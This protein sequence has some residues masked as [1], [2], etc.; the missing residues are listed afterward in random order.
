MLFG[1]IAVLLAA[2]GGAYTVWKRSAVKPAPVVVQ[3]Q[4]LPAG[5]EL[6]LQGKIEAREVISVQ[7][8]SDGT[9]EEYIVSVG[10]EVFE[11]Q[12]LARIHNPAL[13][14]R[15]E[16]AKQ[17]ADKTQ[18][19]VNVMESQLLAARLE[20]SRSRA[21]TSRLKEDYDRTERNFQ[22]Q[23]MLN[24]EGATPRLVFERAKKE[25][26]TTKLEYDAAS[27]R[28]KVAESR[29]AEL[30]KDIEVTKKILEEKNDAL[31]DADLK[32]QA[33]QIHAPVDGIV[34]SRKG[35]AGAEVRLG[36]DDIFRIGTDLGLL[37]MVVEADPTAL[38]RVRPGMPAL[39]ILAE[40]AGEPLIAEVAR[41]ENGKIYVP[42][43]SPDPS[44]KPGLTAQVRLKLDETSTAP[45]AP[46]SMPS[47]ARK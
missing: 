45:I 16:V 28:A 42:F 38:A 23:G 26:E 35:E 9:I 15:R 14:S 11:G 37:Q 22:R 2:A 40:N 4:Q 7:A 13:E 46:P 18:E 8:P 32:L 33:T 36:E 10:E 39:I 19:R 31:E 20:A 17:D 6:S 3:Q 24:R 21:E 34:I 27:G 30:L 43:G 25:F 1:G 5:A 44:I 29:V 41:I 47:D 12:M